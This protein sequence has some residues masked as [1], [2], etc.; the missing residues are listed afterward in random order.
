MRL[1]GGA[2]P[3][4][5]YAASG[6]LEFTWNKSG[7]NIRRRP[8]PGAGSRD[9]SSDDWS[10]WNWGCGDW[11]TAWAWSSDD[12]SKS[13]C[14]SG[15]WWK[16]EEGTAGDSRASASPGTGP[17]TEI[18]ASASARLEP[19]PAKR[20]C[21]GTSRRTAGSDSV[22]LPIAQQ[23]AEVLRHLQASRVVCV[24]GS[25][26]CGKSTQV[27]QY[28]LQLPERGQPH[29]VIVAQPRR[30]AAVQLAKRVAAERGEELGQV[31][32]YAI[33]GDSKRSH[34][35]RLLFVTTG[36]LLE[37]LVHCPYVLEKVTHVVL[38][39]VHE[40]S[41]QADM[42]SLVLKSLLDRYKAVSLVIMSATMCAN[43]FQEYFNANTLE[44]G[45][46]QMDVG[47]SP[48]RVKDVFLDDFG[49]TFPRLT[50]L[51]KARVD[52]IARNFNDGG[53]FDAASGRELSE[54]VDRSAALLVEFF[55]LRV[56]LPGRGQ[57]A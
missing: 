44:N 10:K 20:P 48:F 29:N 12:W 17:P 27:P 56:S 1:A 43:I 51:S 38:D 49:D 39:E 31:V 2:R 30:L 33:G 35:T 55:T 24:N 26:G 36:H 57:F 41:V 9:W 32:G 3:F 15:D 42:L 18:G 25:T 7:G 53:T 28:L 14:W 34:Q 45:V 23:R 52:A 21:T 37:L 19:S 50:R 22:A 16:G 13:N 6:R 5:E 11:G 54:H 8:A 40:R 46:P 47:G 4:C